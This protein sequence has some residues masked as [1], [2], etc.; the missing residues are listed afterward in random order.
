[1]NAVETPA[2]SA[3]RKGSSSEWHQI[4]PEV[5]A[6]AMFCAGRREV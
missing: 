2:K 6:P 1:M 3:N 5:I 4:K